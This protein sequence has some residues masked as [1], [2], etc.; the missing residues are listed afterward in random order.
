M[1]VGLW[2]LEICRQCD[3]SAA[4]CDPRV[5]TR[6]ATGRCRWSSQSTNTTSCTPTSSLPIFFSSREV[7]KWSTLDS[8]STSRRGSVR[9]S[10]TLWAARRSTSAPRRCPASSSRTG[11]WRTRH[12]LDNKVWV[13][14]LMWFTCSVT[15]CWCKKPNFPQSCP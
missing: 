11:H 2:W 3:Y 1:T 9:Q 4:N 15:R 14:P 10:V 12:P 6:L 7:W 5:L 8:R 13:N